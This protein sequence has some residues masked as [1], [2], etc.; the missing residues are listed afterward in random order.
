MLSAN[1]ASGLHGGADLLCQFW[2][3]ASYRIR[4]TNST[5]FSNRKH[6]SVCPA[7][8]CHPPPAPL[9][10][11]SRSLDRTDD[12]YI[13]LHTCS[14]PALSDSSTWTEIPPSYRNWWNHHPSLGVS[15]F[16]AHD[17]FLHWAAT[18]QKLEEVS[19]I[20]FSVPKNFLFYALLLS[21]TYILTL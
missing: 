13:S 6:S 8:W 5:M 2:S 10:P 12:N 3:E 11:V 17:L 1:P 16:G 20:S 14:V 21:P 19:Y 15:D 9:R 4:R 18:T 7:V